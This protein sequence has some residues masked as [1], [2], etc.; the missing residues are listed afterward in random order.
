MNDLSPPYLPTHIYIHTH[1]YTHTALLKFGVTSD[2]V[3]AW[4]VDARV[5]VP[6]PLTQEVGE[7]ETTEPVAA[8]TEAPKSASIFDTLEDKDAAACLAVCAAINGLTTSEVVAGE[9]VC[10]YIFILKR[11]E[12]AIPLCGW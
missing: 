10:V 8:N 9:C 11:L 6:Q 7:G 5:K 2:T 4:C 12:E 1:I 3:K